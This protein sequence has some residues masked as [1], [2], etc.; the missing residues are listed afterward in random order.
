MSKK[1]RSN[2]DVAS[3]RRFTLPKSLILRGKRNF[4]DLFESSSTISSPTVNLK[5]T[6]TPVASSPSFQVAFVA[7][8]KIGNA[9]HRVRCKRLMREVFRLNQHAIQQLCAQQDLILHLALIIRTKDVTYSAVERDMDSLF[10][11]ITARLSNSKS[12]S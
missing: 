2:P 5:F 1:E 8:K 9:V 12:I 11:S 10:S 3:S 6:S 4:Q 7:P